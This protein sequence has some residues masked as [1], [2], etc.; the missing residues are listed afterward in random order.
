MVVTVLPLSQ[1]T[2]SFTSDSAQNINYKEYFETN[3][4][5]G[6][7]GKM[8][9]L[10]NWRIQQEVHILWPAWPQYEI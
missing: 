10:V 8:G 3:E 4:R 7:G 6:R 1:V 9:R 5:E 2:D